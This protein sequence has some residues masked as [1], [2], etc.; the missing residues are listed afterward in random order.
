MRRDAAAG[1][2]DE[3]AEEDEEDE[4][5][6]EPQ[7]EPVRLRAAKAQAARSGRRTASPREDGTVIRVP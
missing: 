1:D 5:D 7:Q 3:V 2:L 6:Q 4:E